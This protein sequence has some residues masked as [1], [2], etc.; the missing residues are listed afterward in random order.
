MADELRT[1]EANLRTMEQSKAALVRDVEFFTDVRDYVTDLVDCLAAKS[2]GLTEL[3]R[4]LDVAREALWRA[5]RER[6]AHDADDG[7]VEARH[8]LLGNDGASETPMER[9]LRRQ[10][11][12]AVT[13]N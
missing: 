1:H 4:D 2:A 5:K 6:A 10:L 7:V 8:A 13:V 3:E 11:R 12:V 9:A